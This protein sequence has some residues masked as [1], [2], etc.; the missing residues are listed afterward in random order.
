MALAQAAAYDASQEGMT[1]RV[2]LPTDTAYWYQP[3]ATRRA[4]DAKQAGDYES[5]ADRI[6][7]GGP[8][9]SASARA[10][11]EREKRFIPGEYPDEERMD[12]PGGR[13]SSW[14]DYAAQ[15]ALEESR[16]DQWQ[17]PVSPWDWSGGP[18]GPPMGEPPPQ[19]Y[20]GAY[21]FFQELQDRGRTAPNV[22][23]YPVNLGS[24]PSGMLPGYSGPPG[25]YDDF[26]TWP[27]YDPNETRY[28]YH[29]GISAPA[30]LPAYSTGSPADFADFS[31]LSQ[32][33]I[34]PGV[35]LSQQQIDRMDPALLEALL[36][37]GTLDQR[38]LRPL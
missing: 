14:E 30:T 3:E 20:D 36:T 7:E 25:L 13:I 8:G 22:S 17:Q 9:L 28:P 10:A 29:V 5:G 23:S 26:K 38:R 33:S 21:D 15:Q 12:A 16:Y 37:G 2:P 4:W 11:F 31:A 35:P 19:R 1:T 34:P 6:L 27:R 18:P 24:P 32:A